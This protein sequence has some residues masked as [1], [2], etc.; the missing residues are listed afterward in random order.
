MIFC[1]QST[2]VGARAR[3]SVG[4]ICV[5]CTRRSSATR[6]ARRR[7]TKSEGVSRRGRARGDLKRLASSMTSRMFRFSG[8]FNCQLRYTRFL[9]TR[10][11]IT[12]VFCSR[13]ASRLS[14]SQKRFALASAAAFLVA[15]EAKLRSHDE[16]QADDTVQKKSIHAREDVVLHRGDERGTDRR[17]PVA[18]RPQRR[19]A[20]DVIF[21]L[22][23]DPKTRR[24]IKS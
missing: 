21:G 4:R 24:T 22:V 15:I 16:H 17:R 12:R 1:C 3:R 6:T 19:R 11:N 20:F 9:N 2:S 14:A 23:H 5:G 8:R 10:T 13:R 7:T 18:L